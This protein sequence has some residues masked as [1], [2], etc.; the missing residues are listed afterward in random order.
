M[1]PVKFLTKSEILIDNYEF[2]TNLSLYD[3]QRDE[4]FNKKL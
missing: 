1:S 2:W 4:S 3:I